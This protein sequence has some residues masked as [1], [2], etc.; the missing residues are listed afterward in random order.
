VIVL[1]PGPCAGNA[2]SGRRVI[3]HHGLHRSAESGPLESAHTLLVG[4][5]QLLVDNMR[6]F[7]PFRGKSAEEIDQMF[8]NK[9]FEPRGPDPVLGL[10]G[11][12]NPRTGRS[13]HID[14]G[15]VY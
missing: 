2:K 7:N 1:A 5:D 3:Y 11:Y 8:R 9:D 12:F 15:G 4:T 13:Y 6:S 10:G 14:P